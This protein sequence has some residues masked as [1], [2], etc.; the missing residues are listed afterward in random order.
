MV[1]TVT[2]MQLSTI[3]YNYPPD[4]YKTTAIAVVFVFAYTLNIISKSAHRS[5]LVSA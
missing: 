5:K 1:S 2:W 4:L 3:S